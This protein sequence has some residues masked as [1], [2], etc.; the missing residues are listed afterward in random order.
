MVRSVRKHHRKAVLWPY[1]LLAPAL[2]IM[3]G[4]VFYPICNAILISFQNYNLTKPGSNAFVGLKNYAELLFPAN[5]LQR[6]DFDFW[7][8]LLRTIV[9]IVFGVGGQ[10]LFG[11]ML[12]LILNKCQQRRDPADR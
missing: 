11:F 7:Q 1:L 9:W 4:V 10:F 8:G 3:I 5:K 2:M 12:A 6:I